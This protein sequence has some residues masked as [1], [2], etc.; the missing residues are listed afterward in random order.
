MARILIVED[1]ASMR[2]ILSVLLASNDYDIAEAATIA[3]CRDQLAKRAFDVLITDQRLPDG[4]GME[5]LDLA[6]EADPG[7]PVIM[8]TAYGTVE[9]AV[10]AMRA[11]A[12]DFITKPF[13]QDT[14][15]AALARACEHG[16]LLRENALLRGEMDR[17]EGDRDLIGDSPALRTVRE[18]IAKVAPTDAT[19]LITGETGTGK[20]LVARLIH[21][22]SPRKTLPFVAVNCA[23][24]PEALLE[25]QLFGHE[26]GAFTGADRPHAGLFEAADRGTLF[27]D[28]AGEMP[29]T[30]QAKLLRVLMDGEVTRVGS[31]TAKRV[32]VRIV[33]ATHRNLEE[34][35]REGKFRE[36]LYYRLAVVP[37]EIPPLRQ[38]QGDIPPLLD[39]FRQV[40][41]RELKMPVRGMSEAAQATLT[42]YPFPGNVRELRNLVERAYILGRSEQ[43]TPRDLPM[44]AEPAT[45]DAGSQMKIPRAGSLRDTLEAVEVELLRAALEDSGGNQAE[46]A[47]QL[48]ITRSD[49]NYKLKKYDLRDTLKS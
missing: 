31:N 1:E 34:R 32:D 43:I 26:K 6:R 41:A 40:V 35:V 36:D 46:A 7:M 3:A 8:L 14:V 12:F 49:M 20:E 10:Q 48:G 18:M 28:E 25:S 45:P 38:R 17:L 23:A 42:A 29:L 27:L 37:I 24:M 39:H 47:R 21:R 4:T 11:G 33:V 15:I 5:V 9:L 2:R 22:N 16:A 44:N 19:V 30:L 13:D